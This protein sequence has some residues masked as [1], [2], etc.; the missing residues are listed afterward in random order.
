[1]CRFYIIV[2]H[3][4]TWIDFLD[5][6]L[7]MEWGEKYEFKY[8]DSPNFMK[9]L[10]EFIFHATQNVSFTLTLWIIAIWFPLY[11]KH[12]FQAHWCFVEYI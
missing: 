1:M 7:Y 8:I 6:A 9:L 12:W 3:V 10:S 11:T 4:N 2:I 5:K